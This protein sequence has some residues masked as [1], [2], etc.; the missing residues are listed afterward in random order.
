VKICG[1]KITPE[2]LAQIQEIISSQPDLTRRQLSHRV[3]ERLDLRSPNGALKDVGCR[4]ALLELHQQGQ[5]ELPK[6]KQHPKVD[7]LAPH[8]ADKSFPEPTPVECAF[9]QLGR[10]RL[11]RIKPGDRKQSRRWNAMMQRHHYLGSGPLCGAQIRYFIESERYGILGGLAF[12]AAAWRVS[13]RDRW[14]GWDD[15][16]RQQHL[17]RVVNNSRFLILPMVKV[18]NLASH[19]LSMAAKQLSID[20]PA[21]YAI[22]PVLLETFVEQG[23][24]SGTCYKAANWKC[25]GQT[26]GRGRQD[27]NNRKLLPVKDVYVY[28]LCDNAIAVLSAGTVRQKRTLS[29]APVDWAEEE[30]ASAQLGDQR[31]VKRLLTIARDFYAHPQANIPQAC[32]T[33]AKTK[34]TYRFFEDDHHNMDTI[35]APHYEAT[36]MRCEQEKVVFAV[37][38]TSSIN[39]ST[40]PATQN[41]GP[42]STQKDSV[43]GLILHDTM[44]FNDEGTPLGL[45][46]VQCW[47]RDGDDF[48]KRHHRRQLPIEQKESYKW[49]KSYQAVT[50]LQAKC[51]DTMFVSVGDRE[52]DIFEL[53]DMALSDP[54][55]PH[56]LVRA[57]H[58]RLLN[59]NNGHL[60][61]HVQR[62]AVS[63]IQEIQLPRQKKRK[64]RIAQLEIR[65]AQV[66]LKPPSWK[67]KLKPLTVWAILAQEINCPDDVKEPLQWMLLT[68]IE[69]KTFEQATQKLAWYAG[70]W[71]IEVYHR[72]LKSGCKI[73]ERQ[74]GSAD[75]IEACLAIDMVIAWRIYY[76]TKL[77]REVPDVPCTVFFDDTEWKA[78]VVYKTQQPIPPDNPPTL[79]EAI[80]LLASLGG[81]LGR[82]SDGEP[83][84]KSLWL[85]F[86]RLDDL[87]MM[88]KIMIPHIN[89]K[90]KSSPSVQY[91]RYG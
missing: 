86:Q 56:L 51:P 71:G 72:T 35:L 27:K 63:G 38:D 62:Q 30:F 60:W 80:R 50:A 33:R 13:A 5:I 21:Q 41:L 31:R 42:I 46:D 4:V 17:N 36:L 47:A 79:R 59:E 34:A 54:N 3:C 28:P 53:F 83:G 85:G 22:E 44:A 65:F 32:R 10:I 64:A 48:G 69:V 89:P 1:K 8:I 18:K 7:R 87:A 68:T 49:L 45:L 19:V 43:I 26:K 29:R 75:R 39:Y 81:F 11:V 66:Q 73:E 82:K 84:T 52:A 6:A 58:D 55:N 77:G 70:R 14:I 37:Q 25:L 15:S 67:N 78:L 20:W 40:H 9:Q 90:N 57:R 88:W 12:S 2:L 61:Q 23:R 74:L 91:P 76:L 16:S 24:F